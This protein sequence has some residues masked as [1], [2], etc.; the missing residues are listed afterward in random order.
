MSRRMCSRPDRTGCAKNT[1]QTVPIGGP[2][3]RALIGRAARPGRA[4]L[5]AAAS[6]A[7]PGQ[8]PPGPP[9]ARGPAASSQRP[10]RHSRQDNSC[11]VGAGRAYRL[12][13]PVSVNF[14]VNVSA[15]GC[16]CMPEACAWLSQTGRRCVIRGKPFSRRRSARRSVCKW[17]YTQTVA[18]R[19]RQ[20]LRSPGL[21]ARSRRTGS[22]SQTRL[23]RRGGGKVQRKGRGRGR[24][25]AGGA[26][27]NEL[28]R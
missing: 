11:V 24:E 1:T 14:R 3:G 26:G 12:T 10:P 16:A 17:A 5:R 19:L 22:L 25:R 9:R 27:A 23:A 15:S 8:T 20:P 28:L 4:C 18:C 7:N 6:G 21:G 2:L 13:R